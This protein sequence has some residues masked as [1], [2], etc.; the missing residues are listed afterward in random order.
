MLK[1]RVKTWVKE[2]N[3]GFITLDGFP[4]DIFVH[5]TGIRMTGYRV[6]IPDEPVEFLIKHDAK[7]WKAVDVVRAE[8]QEH[9]A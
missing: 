5:H 2:G 8:V 6:L 3:Y 4:E 1:G 9:S 7:G